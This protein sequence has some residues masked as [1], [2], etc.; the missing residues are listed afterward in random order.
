MK[1][2]AATA[3]ITLLITRFSPSSAALSGL[4]RRPAGMLASHN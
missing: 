2:S 4:G 1:A 3:L